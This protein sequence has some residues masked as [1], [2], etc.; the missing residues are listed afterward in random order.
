[1]GTALARLCPP[2]DLLKR[3]A[4]PAAPKSASGDIQVFNVFDLMQYCVACASTP[5]PIGFAGE[6][7]ET[8][9]DVA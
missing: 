7:V 3:D 1:V 9:L 4:R 5:R 8:P 6:P 2:Y